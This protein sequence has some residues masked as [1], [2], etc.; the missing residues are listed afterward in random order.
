[1]AANADPF[2]GYNLVVSGHRVVV[3]GTSLATP[4]WAGA[5]ALLNEGL[6]HSIGYL[7]PLIYRVAGPGGAFH[8]IT[9]GDNSIGGVVGYK[10][11]RGWDAVS[12]WGSPDG[13]KLL[14]ALR[15]I[16]PP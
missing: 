1:V 6:G 3:G 11:G 16:K 15:A 12:G 9:D 7:N 2:S 4:F 10:A 13:E 8:D 14:Q 5:V